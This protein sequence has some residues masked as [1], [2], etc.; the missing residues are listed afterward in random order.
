MGCSNQGVRGG[1]PAK[2]AGAIARG[3]LQFM[4]VILAGR[5]LA[6]AARLRLHG[7][8]VV[9]RYLHAAAH[10][11][12]PD[13]RADLGT[14]SDRT[15]RAVRHLRLLLA[16]VCFVGLIAAPGDFPYWLFALLIFGNGVGSGLFASP[17]TSAIM[18]AVPATHRGSA[19]GMRSTFQNSGSRWSHRPSSSR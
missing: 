13:R 9:G 5:H 6:A 8:A 11:G 10:R 19:S 3:G 2:P 14:L 16:A 15:G 12:F 18:S 4:L 7:D 17:N 1:Q